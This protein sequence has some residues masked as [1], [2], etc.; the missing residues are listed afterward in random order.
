MEEAFLCNPSNLSG[1][2]MAAFVKLGELKLM[3]F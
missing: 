3:A 2:E 1:I